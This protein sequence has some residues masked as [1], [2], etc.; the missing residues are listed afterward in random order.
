METVEIYRKSAMIAEKFKE[1]VEKELG[2]LQQEVESVKTWQE[3]YK[4]SGLP[5]QASLYEQK[6]KNL[7]RKIL[8]IKKGVPYPKVSNDQMEVLASVFNKCEPVEEFSF[9]SMPPEVVEA[10]L[11]AKEYKEAGIF[12]SIEVAYYDDDPI[13]IG[14]T[15]CE[16]AGVERRYLLARWGD[17]LKPWEW[18]MN[19]YRNEKRARIA[20]LRHTIHM[21]IASFFLIASYFLL[22]A[23][24]AFDAVKPILLS[25]GVGLLAFSAWSL[26]GR[27]KAQKSYSR[28][29]SE[30]I[31]SPFIT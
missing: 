15:K 23:P 18:F 27:Y 16:I 8:L 1:N 28:L 29:L 31:P 14:K 6:A 3:Y 17:G 20:P 21:L 30:P 5:G 25:L 24:E 7:C 10:Y 2:Y 22:P 19:H 4:T 11:E 13:L 9:Q 26:A 12:D